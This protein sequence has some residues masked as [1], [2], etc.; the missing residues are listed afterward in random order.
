M[1]IRDRYK[2]KYLGKPKKEEEKKRRYRMEELQ[3]IP[4][5]KPIIINDNEPQTKCEYHQRKYNTPK[6]QKIVN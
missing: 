3:E 5:N 1:C 2:T 4:I 6:P